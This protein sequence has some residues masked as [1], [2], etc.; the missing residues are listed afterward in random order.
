MTLAVSGGVTCA[1]PPRIFQRWF[2]I[3][4][5]CAGAQMKMTP[6]PVTTR[7]QLHYH[8]RA[9]SKYSKNAL[10]LPSCKMLMRPDPRRRRAAAGAGGALRRGGAGRGKYMA[11]YPVR[12]R[13][14]ASL[15]SRVC[16]QRQLR[17]RRS[18]RRSASLGRC[19]LQDSNTYDLYSVNENKYAPKARRV[20][21]AVGPHNYDLCAPAHR[22]CV[23]AVL[24]PEARPNS[25]WLSASLVLA[26]APLVPP[27]RSAV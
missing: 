9:I 16:H 27:R 22:P 25:R 20:L 21:Y 15:P 17:G 23:S 2:S 19:R 12:A 13:R 11:H 10:N 26:R 7:V 18:W 3:E 8:F 4:I 24:T 14:G 1:P 5:L 6:P